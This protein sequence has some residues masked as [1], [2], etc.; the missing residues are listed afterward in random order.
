MADRILSWLLDTLAATAVE[1]LVVGGAL[2]AFGLLLYW[3]ERRA[4][5]VM[6]QA[7]GVKATV[8]ATGWIGTTVHELS[9]ALMCLA[10]RHKITQMSLFSPD[11][12]SDV[13]GYVRH[14]WDRGSLYQNLG[15][16]FIGIAPL[17]VGSALVLGL[18]YLLAPGFG[19]V[20]ETAAAMPSLGDAPGYR[21]YASWLARVVG[22]T[23]A[24]LFAPGQL[25]R[26][27]LWVFLYVSLSVTSHLAPSPADL[28]GSWPGLGI[29]LALLFVVNGLLVALGQGPLDWLYR[30]SHWLGSG[31]GLMTLA[32]LLSAASFLAS[33][34]A[35]AIWHGLRGKGI[36]WPV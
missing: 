1:T 23:T 16:L 8:I 5:A 24:A 12:E 35:S 3:L 32:V 36:L 33:Y 4:F 9:H 20:M 31:A 29:L 25:G 11:M 34:V 22:E 14:A 27:Q 30:W 7:F 2:L 28:R 26:W 13:L 15:L 10:F 18:G 19:G 6:G 21:E 17:L